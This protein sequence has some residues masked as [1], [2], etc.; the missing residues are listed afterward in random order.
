MPLISWANVY[1][2]TL[3]KTYADFLYYD[4]ESE[5]KSGDRQT[6]QLLLVP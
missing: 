3:M 2:V 5:L 4:W 6:S 1:D